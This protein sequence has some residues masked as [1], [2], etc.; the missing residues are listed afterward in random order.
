MVGLKRLFL[1]EVEIAA[2]CLLVLS[3]FC[4][5]VVVQHIYFLSLSHRIGCRQDTLTSMSSKSAIDLSTRYLIEFP[6]ISN[7][8]MLTIH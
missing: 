2:L 3:L 7:C 8:R 1:L 5:H 4:S 6:I